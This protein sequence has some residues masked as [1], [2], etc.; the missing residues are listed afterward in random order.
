ML[1]GIIMHIIIIASYGFKLWVSHNNIFMKIFS[2]DDLDVVI[3]PVRKPLHLVRN[4][5]T[6]YCGGCN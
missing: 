3:L 2:G 6:S 5:L 4:Y 1:T